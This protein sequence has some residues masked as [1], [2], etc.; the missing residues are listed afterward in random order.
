MTSV[1]IDDLG[2]I[3]MKSVPVNPDPDKTF[4]ANPRQ[5]LF[6]PTLFIHHQRSQ[7]YH[8]GSFRQGHQSIHHL[9]YG[10]RTDLLPAL[11]T[12]GMATPGEQQAQMIV[13]LSNRANS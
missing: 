3:R 9:L 10:L 11:R 7:K 6:M 4:L 13:N 1:F 5:N 8:P 12:K 2:L